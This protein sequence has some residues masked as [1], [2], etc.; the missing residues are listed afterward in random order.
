MPEASNLFDFGTIADVLI[1]LDYTT[2]DSY[3]YRQQVLR[4]LDSRVSADRPFSFRHQLADQWYDL[5]N[6]DQTATPMTVRF[7]ICHEDFPPNVQGI[8]IQHVV[9]YFARA[10]G[11]SFEVD[12]TSLKLTGPDGDQTV[13][14]GASSIDGLISTRSGNAGGWMALIGR[15]PLGE[16]ELSLPDA[17]ETR[18]WFGTEQIEDILFVITYRGETPPW[19][20]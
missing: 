14:E 2:L 12:V 5:H 3:D 16:W 7:Q 4:E 15:S 9:F 8:K 6:P 10:E 1:T 18:N 19:P 13:G 17:P 20:A 11:A